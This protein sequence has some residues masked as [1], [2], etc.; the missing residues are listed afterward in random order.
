VKPVLATPLAAPAT[1]VA[2]AGGV[3]LAAVT[4][5][6]VA[7]AAKPAGALGAA[8]APVEVLLSPPPIAAVVTAGACA[9]APEP[10]VA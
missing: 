4:D 10:P 9:G 3:S 6:L 7:A 8:D 1:T 5:V 2:V